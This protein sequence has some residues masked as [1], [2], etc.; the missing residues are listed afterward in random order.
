MGM[1]SFTYKFVFLLHL[2]AVVVGFGSAFVYPMLSSRAR[3]LEPKEAYAV[4]HAAYGIGRYLTSYPIYAAIVF[5][6]LL[7]VLSDQNFKFS[8]TWVSVAFVV[9]ICAVLLN[10]FLH[11][12]NLKAMD[13]LQEKLANGT[14]TP[15]KDGKP[16]EV[17][18]LQERGSRAGMYGGVLH[19]FFL[20]LMIDM[21]WKPGLITF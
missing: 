14:V 12:P 2:T 4:N 9:V 11:E 17:T 13:A 19:L 1:D 7:V 16:K 15:G 6:I 8:Q 5:G 18:E 21:I 10:V 20:I 3:K